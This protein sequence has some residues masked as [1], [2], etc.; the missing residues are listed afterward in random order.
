MNDA[1]PASIY[2]GTSEEDIVLAYLYALLDVSDAMK[3]GDV[4]EHLSIPEVSCQSMLTSFACLFETEELP[5]HLYEGHFCGQFADFVEAAAVDV[6]VGEVIQQVVP[7]FDTQ[8]HLQHLCPLRADAW[9]VG[10]GLL[11]KVFHYFRSLGVVILMFS[12]LPSIISILCPVAST[13]DASS[14]KASE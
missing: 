3:P 14:V 6:L 11:P 12:L 13:T 4:E 5:Q 8:L 9:Q 2:P 7:G 1:E 10:D